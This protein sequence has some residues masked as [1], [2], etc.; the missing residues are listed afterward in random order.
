MPP[1]SVRSGLHVSITVPEWLTYNGSVPVAAV[2]LAVSNYG[3][4]ENWSVP[5]VLAMGPWSS[6]SVLHFFSTSL[7]FVYTDVHS[8]GMC[9]GWQN[10]R[11]PVGSHGFRSFASPAAFRQLW[12]ISRVLGSAPWSTISI[13]ASFSSCFHNDFDGIRSL[14]PF[15]SA[16]TQL[17]WLSSLPTSS[18][19][20]CSF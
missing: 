3:F 13:F 12:S 18:D 7:P 6:N 20:M 4:S 14:V 2:A 17:S 1:S 10:D 15:V 16:G 19:L 5:S 9:W 8:S 11:L